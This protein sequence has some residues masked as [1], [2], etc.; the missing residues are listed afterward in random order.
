MQTMQRELS[1]FDIYVIVSELQDLKG[2]YIE[3]IYQLARDELLIRIKKGNQKEAIFVRNESLL[4]RTDQQFTAPT[5]PSTFAMTL[6]KYLLNGKITEI[7]Q[8]EF[9]RIVNIRV[10]KKEGIYSLVFEL[11]KNGNIL[12]LNP[13]NKIIVPLIRQRWAH[14]TIRGKETYVPPPSQ[15]NPFTLNKEEFTELLKKSNKDLVRTL[16]VNMNLSGTYAEE[17][18]TRA[19]IDKNIDTKGMD[20]ASI[21]KIYSTLVAF[22]EIFNK[23]EFQPIA[24][25][26]NGKITDILPF[27]FETYREKE[28]VAIES[29]NEGLKQTT[30]EKKEIKKIPT[31]YENKIEKLKRQLTQQNKSVEEFKKK[32]EQKK[33]EGDVIYLHF[34]QCEELLNDI[35]NLLKQK[36]KEE[37][38]E[39]INR[40]PIVKEFGPIENKL[41]VL[42][43]DT[44]SNKIELELDFRKNVAENAERAYKES[45]KFAEK[46]KGAEDAIDTTKKQL[47]SVQQKEKQIQKK[48][49]K[50]AI[51]RKHYWFENYRWSLSSEGNIIIAGKDAKSNER[52]VKKYLGEG[53]RYVHADIHGASSCIVKNQDIHEK[54][55]DVSGQ[56][57]QEACIFASCYSKAWKQYGEAQ[58]YWVLPEQVSKTPQSGEFLAKGAFVIR[59]KRNYFRCKLELA[60]GEIKVNDTNKIMS[61]AVESIKKHTNK[62]V[63]LQPGPMKRK[64]IIHMLSKAFQ[65]S[66]DE[67][68]NV[69]P[70]GDVEIVKTVGVTTK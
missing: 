19:G 70:P 62:Y 26:D 60:I 14:R 4:C 43:T 33:R 20:D 17:L 12:L 42:L 38:L 63:V 61:G 59:G 53:D 45:K 51:E 1:S 25:K 16:A 5:K 49:K 23:K 57:L 39:R 21:E 47:Q 69:L 10:Q 64:D 55:I 65:V 15:I 48:E 36:E 31:D 18:C 7:T 27:P 24:I 46:V 34:Q 41:I 28:S 6:R 50:E 8:H 9:D 56:T 32:I 13:E 52:I 40:N 11:F 58:T 37:G 35:Q 3:K 30:G 67:I 44:N 2:S 68:M 29:F 22:L 66:A 54:K